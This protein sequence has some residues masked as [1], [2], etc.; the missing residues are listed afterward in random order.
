MPDCTHADAGMVRD[1]CLFGYWMY[2]RIRLASP[3]WHR[4]LRRVASKMRDRYHTRLESITRCPACG[5][6]RETP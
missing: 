1:R 5:R 4:R 3:W 2:D 6:W